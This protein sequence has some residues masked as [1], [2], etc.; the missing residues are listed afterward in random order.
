MKLQVLAGAAVLALIAG[1]ASA[2]THNH[3]SA[4]AYAEPSQ[5]V[6]YA[7]LDDYLKASPAKR[8]KQDWS[9]GSTAQASTAPTG[10]A[11]NTS[12]T[13]PQEGAAPQAGMTP[14]NAPAPAPDSQTAPPAQ[15]PPDQSAPPAGTTA[16]PP[17]G[18]ATPD[19]G[20]APQTPGGT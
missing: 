17:S 4:G 18:G 2:A 15:S 12:A 8:T 11:A 20:T 19:T 16:P 3:K 14:N 13:A 7:K 1:G 5:P 6:A 9:L 10:G